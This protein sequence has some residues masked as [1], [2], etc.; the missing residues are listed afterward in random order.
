MGRKSR[1]KRKNDAKRAA[2]ESQVKVND[3]QRKLAEKEQEKEEALNK[4]NEGKPQ[5]TVSRPLRLPTNTSSNAPFDLQ[6]HP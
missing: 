2:D 6:R 3:V 5:H 4:A 1:L